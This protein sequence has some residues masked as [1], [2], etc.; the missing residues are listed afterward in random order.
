LEDIK[1]IDFGKIPFLKG[2]NRVDLVK[3]IPHFEVITYQSGEILCRKGDIGDSFFIIVT[4]N[5]SVIVCNEKG[6]CEVALLGPNDVFGEMQLLTGEPRSA[7]VK[8][9]T[10]LKVLR[11]KKDQFDK[12]MRELR[13]SIEAALGWMDRFGDLDGDGMIT[14]LDARKLTLLCTRP[15][16]AT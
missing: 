16:C 11:L 12:L 7:E 3:L 6:K 13:P 2:L 10:E 9:S 15:R 8:A 4:G 1:Q 14:A 5:A